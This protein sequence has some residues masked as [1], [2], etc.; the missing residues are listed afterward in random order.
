[1]TPFGSSRPRRL[2]WC[3]CA[4]VALVAL[5]GVA[6]ASGEPRLITSGEGSS[7]YR[8]QAKIN[9]VDMSQAPKVR[10]FASLLDRRFKTVALD[11]IKRV[12]VTETPRHGDKTTL[13]TID[14]EQE[15]VVWPE[16]F[17]HRA[18]EEVQPTLTLGEEQ[19]DGMAS[20]VVVNGYDGTIDESSPGYRDSELG[21]RVLGGVSLFFQQ[22]GKANM[23]NVIWYSDALRMW[24]DAPGRQ[25]EFTYLSPQIRS[26]CE[27]AVLASLEDP[28]ASNE[29]PSE[30]EITCGLTKKYEN[31]LTI[32]ETGDNVFEGAYPRLFNLDW[33]PYTSGSSPGDYCRK[34]E[35]KRRKPRKLMEDDEEDV[36]AAG[37]PLAVGPWVSEPSAM[38]LA[39]EMLIRDAGRG[40]QKTLILLSDGKDGYV[41]RLRECKTQWRLNGPCRSLRGRAGRDC[42][43]EW[44]K[45]A[46][47]QE[48]SRFSPKAERWIGLAKAA[49][50]RIFSVVHPMAETHE[51]ERLEVLS[52]KTGGTA[53][54]AHSIND[55]D[56]AYADLIDELN[57]Q[58]VL[59][60]VDEGAVPWEASEAGQA[61]EGLPGS[62][63]DS[64]ADCEQGGCLAGFCQQERSYVL[65]L[66]VAFPNGKSRK[67]K[68]GAP[69][70]VVMIPSPEVSLSGLVLGGY[71][72]GEAKLGKTGMMA[73]VIGIALVLL[74]IL[75]KVLI[76]LVKKA[77]KGKK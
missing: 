29:E 9:W 1:M 22:L 7:K 18:D 67:P 2:A 33:R 4:V 59:E 13:F 14:R 50:V 31:F 68:T 34:P 51:R 6:L 40:Q 19:L 77:G 71:A 44:L 47:V 16:E 76:G 12:T 11:D 39:L 10:I 26:D 49:G 25:G 48:Q 60:F 38:D 21:A 52:F 58:L 46:V 43:N 62:E 70:R 37:D 56:S 61:V 35:V 32:L 54:V 64:H 74:L 24:I 69:Y 73:L 55:L 23:M 66:E 17:A 53:R 27:Q 72:S 57:G 75:L 42:I 30:A 65:N 5:T 20:V 28:S 15:T 8:L 41:H 36:E 45:K 63:C 3:A